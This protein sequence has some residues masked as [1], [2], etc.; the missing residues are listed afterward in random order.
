MVNRVSAAR[1]VIVTLAL[2]YGIF[3]TGLAFDLHNGMRTHKADLGQIDQAVWNSSRG[4]FVEM[5]DNGFVATRMT[6]HVEPILALISPVFWFWNDVRALL[7]LQAVAVALG[8]WLLFEIVLAVL[9]YKHQATDKPE[10]NTTSSISTTLA[11]MPLCAVGFGL[12]WLLSPMLQSALL[13]EFHAAPLAVPFTLWAFWSVARTRWR[14]AVASIFLLAMVK[15]EMALLAAGLGVWALWQA[16]LIRRA[17]GQAGASVFALLI[18]LICFALL[19]FAVATFVIV[20]AHAVQVYGVAESSYFQRYGALGNSPVD[21][22]K[23]FFVRP[24]VVWQIIME[25]ARLLYGW[26]LLAAFGFFSLLAPEIL[27][28]SL[29]LLL[30]NILSA[31]PAQYYGEF[32]YSAP[33]MPYFAVSAVYGLGR[34]WCWIQRI[35]TA[36]TSGRPTGNNTSHRQLSSRLSSVLLRLAV[37]LCCVWLLGWGI[38]DYW[39]FGR[40]PGGGRYDPVTITE[41]H[42]LLPQLVAQIPADAAVTATAAVHPHVSHRRYVYQFPLGLEPPTVINTQM[43]AKLWQPPDWALLDVTTNTDMAPG[44]LQ[45]QVF[46]MLAADWGVVVGVDGFLLLQRGAD[47]KEIPD[48]FYSFARGGEE[49]PFTENDVQ[50]GLIALATSVDDWPQ[51]RATKVRGYWQIGPNFDAT[52]TSPQLEVRTSQGDLLYRLTDNQ[53]P[54]YLWYPPTRWQ[55]GEVI[56]ITSPTLYLPQSWG[57]AMNGFQTTGSQDCLLD[58]IKG[59]LALAGVYQRN[60]L[61]RLPDAFV[62]ADCKSV[63]TSALK[64]HNGRPTVQT[65]AAFT[66]PATTEHEPV[67]AFVQAWLPST[68]IRLGKPLAL[69]LQ[70]RG[71]NAWPHELSVFVHLRHHG[72]NYAQQDGT[73]RFFATMPVVNLPQAAE[74]DNQPV[75]YDWRQLY[76]TPSTEQLPSRGWQLF[77]GLYNPENGERVELK[78]GAGEVIGTE[79]NVGEL[80]I[81]PTHVPDQTCA[82]IPPTCAAQ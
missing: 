54:A 53:A 37:G 44:D 66:L 20:P 27:L 67:E 18:L 48:S 1:W 40:G 81:Q 58:G 82:L 61:G 13:T 47:S 6:D 62:V 36:L 41:H 14:Q 50:S 64:T 31:Y 26:R 76:L 8:A 28:L 52:F 43:D 23:S 49:H 78:N 24:Q 60:K 34:G 10:R 72:I 3:F 45:A 79:L 38:L 5:T 35:G 51:W 69:L 21:I 68:E 19:W 77:I 16:F 12:A 57:V 33:L 32:H 59:Q 29:P 7:L 11:M 9:P 65:D 2:L 30:A 4:R 55:H 17:E 75:I 46:A 70:W 63:F 15:E 42:R 22:A 80:S 71:L 73:P 56:Q 25:P 74:E 39:Q